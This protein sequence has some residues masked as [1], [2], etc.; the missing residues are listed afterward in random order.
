MISELLAAE[1]VELAEWKKR[2]LPGWSLHSDDAALVEEMRSSNRLLIDELRDGLRIQAKAWVGVV[3]LSNGFE[4]R[5]VPK[6]A[7]DQLGL[8]ELSSTRAGS[9]R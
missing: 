3:R 1:V 2:D 9:R 5:V 8:V 7:G 4:V 6:L